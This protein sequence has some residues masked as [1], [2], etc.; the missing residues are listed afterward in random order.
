VSEQKQTRKKSSSTSGPAFTPRSGLIQR[1]CACGGSA[2]VVGECA[3]CRGKRL[4][5]QRSPVTQAEPATSVPPVVHD[6]L[7]SPG[8]PSSADTV[9]KRELR[10]GY[11]FERVS[12]YPTGSSSI[13]AKLIVNK[14]GD[15]YEQEAD[16]VA[17]QVMRVQEPE[18]KQGSE[19]SGQ[20][21]NIS[22]QNKLEELH[23]QPEKEE[24]E[25]EEEE[26]L[27]AKEAQ[28]QTLK[29][30]PELQTRI[31]SIKGTGQPLLTATRASVEP[32]FGYDF[33][34]VRIH[35]DA[36][37]AEMAQ[38]I[39]A[40]AFTLDQDIVFGTGEYAP[41]T[42]D[43]KR[44]LA[45][46]LTHVVQQRRGSPNS[47]GI[48][49]KVD[50]SPVQQTEQPAVSSTQ[51][52]AE[53]ERMLVE[54]TVSLAK[55]PLTVL[56]AEDVRKVLETRRNNPKLLDT[57]NI[58][59][60]RLSELGQV[61]DSRW[62]QLIQS[63]AHKLIQAVELEFI[64]DPQASTLDLLAGGQGQQYRGLSWG[65]Y[66]YPGNAPPKKLQE[67]EA[68][69]KLRIEHQKAARQMTHELNKVR[70]ERRVNTGK[71]AVM[72]K[73]EFNW[74]YVESELVAVHG[75][76]KHKLNHFAKDSF[77]QMH[78]DALQDGVKLVIL[79]SDRSPAR[80]KQNALRA[81]NPTA[82]AKFSAHT[83]GLAVDLQ[84]SQDSQKYAE[85]STRPMQNVVNMHESPVHKWMFL[86]GAA[87]G[88]YP[89]QNEPWH[90]EYNP[91]GFREKF[92]ANLHKSSEP[93]Q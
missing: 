1:K 7:S 91:P 37:A 31:T 69:K 36:D 60:R 85:I 5:V 11:D 73:S 22:T 23:R 62:H 93:S 16:H 35:A 78:K 72:L 59:I 10:A 75:Q 34:D 88:W 38:A 53:I 28:G 80:A 40:R 87:Y 82:V 83:L 41:E 15:K 61:G 9:L 39:N 57:F 43:G 58:A 25:K 24:G 21:Q 66:D 71:T 84:M 67:D 45:H 79:A 65:K 3:E 27:Q 56:H 17:E 26:S 90:W 52:Q 89:Y 76:G 63:E 32:R 42:M 29:I 46:E 50:L 44:L 77:V 64:H 81:G 54:E 51:Q 48:Q 14:P 12:I 13:Q 2:G 33:N 68:S 20:T 55:L 18:D 74:E 8:Q 49:R 4:S 70:S 92:L 47:D 6:V 19:V 86:H 30:T